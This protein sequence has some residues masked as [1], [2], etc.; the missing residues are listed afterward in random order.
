V[1]TKI[2]L[3]KDFT[4]GQGVG[5]TN[6]FAYAPDLDFDFQ[7]I[8]TMVFAVIDEL[9]GV[10]GPNSLLARDMLEINDSA[11]PGGVL[12]SG[13]IGEHSFETVVGSPTSELD[14]SPGQAMIS[15][16]RVV[17]PNLTV[18]PGSGGTGTRWVNL[19]P[20]G[21]VSLQ[22]SAAAVSGGLDI[23]SATWTGPSGPFSAVVQLARIF[24]DGD[25]Y[26]LQVRRLAA[27]GP[28]GVPTFPVFSYRAVYER[29]QSLERLL[30]GVQT[31]GGGETL[32][33]KG[34]GG[35]VGAPGLILTDG[36]T[37]DATSGL[38]RPGANRLGVAT[39]G[40]QSLEVDA[41]GNLDLPSNARVKG[42]RTAVLSVAD[43]TPT[44]VS[45]TAA[46][47]FDVGAAAWHNAGGGAPGDQEFT[48]PTGADGLYQIVAAVEWAAP[49]TA[50]DWLIEITVNGTADQDKLENSTALAKPWSDQLSIV[51]TLAAGDVVRLRVTQVDTVGTA[52]LDL[53]TAS[54]AIV[55]IA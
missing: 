36:T 18:L 55:K 13:V 5:P 47:A 1:A 9:S 49:A 33:P 10:Q 2:T 24:F 51:R 39:S 26:D 54:I 40:V 44:L 28:G 12:S 46:D 25:D 32:G 8:E 21:T 4:G 29:L 30:A 6:Y 17:Q 43:N 22:T 38:Y 27:V 16:A 41:Q 48:V 45:F 23:A 3:R 53:Q 52:A 14:V 11:H 7:S 15:G 50:T 20:T 31:G 42:V 19:G 34:F 35:A 37:F